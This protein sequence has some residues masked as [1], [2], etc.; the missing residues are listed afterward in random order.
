[1]TIIL[2]PIWIIIYILWLFFLPKLGFALYLIFSFLLIGWPLLA[3]PSAKATFEYFKEEILK[4]LTEKEYEF[5]IKYAVFYRWPFASREISSMFS[6]LYLLNLISAAIF[7]FRR[8]FL[9]LAV[10]IVSIPFFLY[11]SSKY[12]PNFFITQKKDYGLRGTLERLCAERVTNFMLD[13]RPKILE[14]HSKNKREV[15]KQ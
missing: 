3:Y 2:A 13:N 15:E 12:N 10:A 6:L 11:F 4:H 5:L 8:D 14:K 7:L 9:F 1:M